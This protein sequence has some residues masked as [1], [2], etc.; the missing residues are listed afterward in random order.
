MK[1]IIGFNYFF[2]YLCIEIQEVDFKKINL[3]LC[4]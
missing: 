4:E 3:K 2:V 1:Q